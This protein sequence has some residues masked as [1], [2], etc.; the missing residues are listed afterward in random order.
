MRLLPRRAG[1]G[2]IPSRRYLFGLPHHRRGGGEVT[3]D[4]YEEFLA[5]G[6]RWRVLL[7]QGRYAWPLYDWEEYGED[8]QPLLGYAIYWRRVSGLTTLLRLAD[9]LESTPANGQRLRAAEQADENSDTS[10]RL[11]CI[12]SD[13]CKYAGQY[14]M[15]SGRCG[16]CGRK[17]TDPVS[18]ARG[19]GPDCVE[20]LAVVR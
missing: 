4:D 2:R 8:E 12:V 1:A 19:I 14:G 3:E 17:L 7:P 16:L 6:L 18:V 15:F 13:P 11:A 20:K 5:R 10:Y 9:G